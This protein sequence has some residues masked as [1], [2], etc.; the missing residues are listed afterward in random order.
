MQKQLEGVFDEVSDQA[1]ARQPVTSAS[2]FLKTMNSDFE[3][4]FQKRAYNEKNF[5]FY[6]QVLAQQYKPEQVRKA[7][8]KM[9]ALGIEPTD[10]TYT[11]LMLAHAK[12]GMLAEVLDLE[13][14]ASVKHKIMPSIHRLNS[15]L[16]A[17]V[18]NKEPQKASMFIKEMR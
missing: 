11:Q 1:Q 9:L 2:T 6:L 18:K 15:V 14:E 17:Y 3:V 4:F 7:F 8:D 16:L 5:S 12:K 10:H 13:N